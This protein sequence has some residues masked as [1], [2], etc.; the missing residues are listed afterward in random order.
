VTVSL[1]QPLEKGSRPFLKLREI[2]VLWLV[3]GGGCG[4]RLFIRNH[5]TREDFPRE[6]KR[7]LLADASMTSAA[8]AR[9]MRA[10]CR[11]KS[12]N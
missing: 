1:S 9:K 11:P 5:L 3:A 7:S 2:G 4:I 8:H 10:P 12:R 6:A